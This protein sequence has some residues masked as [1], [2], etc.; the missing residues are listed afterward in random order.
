M[1]I[2]LAFFHGWGLSGTF[3]APLRAALPDYPH[4][5]IDRGYFGGTSTTPWHLADQWVAIGHSKGWADAL[6]YP[7]QQKDAPTWR[8][9][10][11]LCGFT[12]FCARHPEDAGQARRVVERMVKVFGK[13]PHEVLSDFLTRCELQAFSPSPEA[14]ASAV[15]DLM[16]LQSDL[17]ALIDMDVS[18]WLQQHPLPHLALAAQ[19][20]VIVSPALSQATWGNAPQTELVW[21]PTGGHA[22]G[23]AHADWCALQIRRFVNGLAHG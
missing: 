4:A 14:E 10:I 5:V 6:L 17:A 3:W 20:D 9:T 22:L 16:H 21:H 7:R 15:W 13:A 2:G 12:H 23:Y 11:S 19:D 8:A 1:S 18:D